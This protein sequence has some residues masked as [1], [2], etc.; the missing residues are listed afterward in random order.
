MYFFPSKI[1][2][3]H[4]YVGPNHMVISIFLFEYDEGTVSFIPIDIL[5]LNVSD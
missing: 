3:L 5:P 2:K 4:N 1:V